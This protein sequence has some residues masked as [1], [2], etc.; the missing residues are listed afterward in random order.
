MQKKQTCIANAKNIKKLHC[1][2]KL[3]EKTRQID[4][5]KTNLHCRRKTNKKFALPMQIGKKKLVKSMQK[6]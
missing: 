6:I 4:A 2:C 3:G 5:K 1:Q